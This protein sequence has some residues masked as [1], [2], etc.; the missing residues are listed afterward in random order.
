MTM[1]FAAAPDPWPQPVDGKIGYASYSQTAPVPLSTGDTG[2]GARLDS[3]GRSVGLVGA[4][5]G[6]VGAGA[7]VFG[8]WS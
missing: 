2:A 7:G 4:V 5:A 1:V 8:L 3:A 6:A